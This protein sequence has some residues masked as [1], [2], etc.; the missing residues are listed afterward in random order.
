MVS[1]I[2]FQALHRTDAALGKRSES[3]RP[4][5]RYQGTADSDCRRDHRYKDRITRQTPSLTP[6]SFV[7]PGDE[8]GGQNDESEWRP[9]E[10]RRVQGRNQLTHVLP[11][12]LHQPVPFPPAIAGE[13]E[14]HDLYG[15]LGHQ[16]PPVLNWIP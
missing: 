4:T 13:I 15:Q 1:E 6:P 14:E 12:I 10:H 3:A 8:P 2:F 5:S 7:P 16:S 11:P 9:E